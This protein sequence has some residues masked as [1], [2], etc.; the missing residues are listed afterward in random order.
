[1]KVAMKVA[2]ISPMEVAAT[3][4]MKATISPMEV[5]AMVGGGDRQEPGAIG[6]R[7]PRAQMLIHHAIGRVGRVDQHW[8]GH[9]ARVRCPKAGQLE[10]NRVQSREGRPSGA[11]DLNCNRCIL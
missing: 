5:W 6:S 8:V 3:R 7:Q 4:L 11:D 10:V 9:L 1:M 2:A